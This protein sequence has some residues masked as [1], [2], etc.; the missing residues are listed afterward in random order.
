M[1]LK[2]KA[3]KAIQ[4]LEGHKKIDPYNT[5]HDLWLV[6]TKSYVL[7]FFG[8]QSPEYEFISEFKTNT[9]EAKEFI[10]SVY[11]DGIIDIYIQT[12][13]NKGVYKPPVKNFL[14]KMNDNVLASL[15]VAVAT[16]I[17]LIGKDAGMATTNNQNFDLRMDVSHLKDSLNDLRAALRSPRNI[18]KQD[19]Q[20]NKNT[21]L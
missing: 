15:L 16:G 17:F 10:E 21:H 14:Q 19:T 7:E 5:N 12:I 4:I 6:Q 20:S 3:E 18:P 11:D 2:N 13:K 9:D 1:I 8:A